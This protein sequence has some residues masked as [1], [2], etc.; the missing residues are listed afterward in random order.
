[1]GKVKCGICGKR[2]ASID[3]YLKVGRNHNC[4]LGHRGI[5]MQKEKG[6]IWGLD[7]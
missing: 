2:Y 5:F 3:E 4:R 1:M 6:L 7:E